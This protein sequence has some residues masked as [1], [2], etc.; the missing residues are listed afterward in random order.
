MIFASDPDRSLGMDYYITDSY[1]CGGVIKSCAEDFQV[2]E[3]FEEL[4]Y[5]G[6]RYLVL[7]VE[8]TNWDTHHLIREMA[9]KLR[10]SQKR[11][12]WAGTKDKRAVTSQRISIMNLD[13]SSLSRIT[14][15]DLKIRVLG[16][17]NRAV[18]LGDLLGNSFRIT[19]RDL[20]CPDPANRFAAITS[21]IEKQSGVPNYFGIQRFGDIRPVT[22][23]VGEAMVR[24]RIEEAVFIYLAL[25]FPGEPER[26]RLAREK[27]WITRD[28]SAALKEFPEYLHYEVAMLNFLVEHPGDY[29]HSFDVLSINLKRLFVHAYQSYLFNRILSRRMAGAMPLHS[30][31][32]GDVV[33]FAREGLPDMDR[34]QKVTTENLEAI[35]RLAKRSRAFLTL[36]LIG[37][38]TAIEEG[39]QGEIERAIL[40][41][42][43][44]SPENFRVEGNPDLGSRGTRR[45]ALCPVK[46]QITVEE[47]RAE[48]Q[49]VLPKGSYATVV[50]REYMKSLDVIKSQIKDLAEE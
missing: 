11:F 22:H 32:V 41:E 14:L 31:V 27:L 36:P 38:E 24:G 46:P 13:E 47:N 26:T 30:A 49:F 29:A 8:K 39:A 4:G 9:R 33:C 44:I 2:S 15:P 40:R 43:D 37:F 21:E 12:G 42:E 23:K 10:I 3:V 18:G 19:I 20:S 28:I 35:D 34:V 25:P 5:E 48:L 17:T 1:G 45:A 7:D 16:K 50:L 6:G